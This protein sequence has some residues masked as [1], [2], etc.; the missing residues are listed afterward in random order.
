MN[1][2]KQNWF[3]SIF[4]RDDREFKRLMGELI[5]STETGSAQAADIFEDSTRQLLADY[6]VHIDKT[7][8]LYQMRRL[9]LASNRDRAHRLRS[10][11]NDFDLRR[12]VLFM[13]GSFGLLIALGW[14]VLHFYEFLM[15]W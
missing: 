7:Q 5:D 3:H 14:P 15:A 4:Y 10:A 12:W 11:P 8:Y 9:M 1:E 2:Q 6:K 13:F